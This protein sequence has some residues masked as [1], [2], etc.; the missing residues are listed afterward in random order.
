MDSS[1]VFNSL[2]TNLATEIRQLRT[3]P[4]PESFWFVVVLFE[5][6]T[7]TSI[8]SLSLCFF[9]FPPTCFFFFC[10]ISKHLTKQSIHGPSIR[11]IRIVSSSNIKSRIADNVTVRI[12]GTDDAIDNDMASMKGVSLAYR[13]GFC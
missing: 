4:I 13:N 12:R 1:P 5:S 7:T 6:A 2:A 11:L 9:F 3:C 10:S 8:E